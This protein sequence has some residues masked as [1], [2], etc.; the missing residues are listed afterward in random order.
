[1]NNK[2]VIDGKE[3]KSKEKSNKE[4]SNKEKEKVINSSKELYKSPALN[5]RGVF[6]FDKL[7]QLKYFLRVVFI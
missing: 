1:M 5:W 6:V 4:K 2:E 3:E 7:C